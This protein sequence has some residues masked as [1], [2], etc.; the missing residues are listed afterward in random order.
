[1]RKMF[2][3]LTAVLT[4][5][6]GLAAVQPA[7]AQSAPSAA[8][9]NE[10]FGPLIPLVG[11]TWRGQA[12]GDQPVVDY[13]RWEWAIGGHAIRV[14]HALAD[15]SYGGETVIFPDRDSGQL[16]F[17]YFT[18]GGF[19]STGA[20]TVQADGSLVFD[21]TLH[22]VSGMSALRSIWR[23]DETGYQTETLN[24]DGQPFGGFNYTDAGDRTV[25]DLISQ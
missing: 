20:M 17:H 2:L 24:Q 18:S 1:M 12:M 8:P 4:L 10:L 15:G 14:T 9:F 5:G 13:A 6:G 25:P 3:M 16:T 7:K 11:R 21:E 19:H 23:I 22:G